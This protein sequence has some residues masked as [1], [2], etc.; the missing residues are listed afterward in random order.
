[1]QIT[2]AFKQWMCS[3]TGLGQCVSLTEQRVQVDL[4]WEEARE[5]LW[6]SNGTLCSCLQGARNPSAQWCISFSGHPWEQHLSFVTST[7]RWRS[8]WC[9]LQIEKVY[10]HDMPG[11]CGNVLPLKPFTCGWQGGISSMDP[12]TSSSGYWGT[13]GLSLLCWH[14]H[15]HITTTAPEAQW[16]WSESRSSQLSWH[17][18]LNLSMQGSLLH[19]H[20]LLF[21]NLPPF[22]Y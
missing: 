5:A 21:H 4:L 22:I 12:G 3:R 15:V 10:N 9:V 14:E 13:A 2:V 1:M 6:A 19:I 16:T 18:W 7:C 8:T 20:G 11:V 17:C